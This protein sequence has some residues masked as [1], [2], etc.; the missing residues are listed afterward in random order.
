MSQITVTIGQI[1][2]R[3]AQELS[4]DQGATIA[5]AIARSGLSTNG[6]EIRVNNVPTRE[7]NTPL[8]DEDFVSLVQ[9]IK[10]N[11]G[12]LLEIDAII[13]IGKK[14]K[15][16]KFP[17]AKGSLLVSVK[18]FL[19][20]PGKFA[21]YEWTVGSAENCEKSFVLEHDTTIKIVKKTNKKVVKKTEKAEKT[22]EKITKAPKKAEKKVD[23]SD[24]MEVFVSINGGE[25]FAKTLPKRA[26][27]SALLKELGYASLKDL[28]SMV[29]N[30]KTVTLTFFEIKAGANVEITVEEAKTDNAPKPDEAPIKKPTKKVLKK[31]VKKTEK[32]EKTEEKAEK[33]EKK[34]TKKTEEA[35]DIAPTCTCDCKCDEAD[36]KPC[37]PEVEV[38]PCDS[39][40]HRS[41]NEVAYNGESPCQMKE[42]LESF[43]NILTGIAKDANIK[44]DSICFSE[45]KDSY[46]VHT[47]GEYN[48]RIMTSP[49][50]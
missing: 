34:V 32:A 3:P 30:G 35:K 37:P 48:L 21:D 13:T 27:V 25:T 7:L 46:G 40:S 47:H 2:G 14:E 44:V 24:T 38:A 4:L 22:E 16:Q 31:V 20:L 42:H 6:Y 33:A 49:I 39:P 41:F 10:G 5:D 23:A 15:K 45:A 50:K 43:V 17:L 28:K 12:D 36:L 18:S 19:S 26:R 29:V 11:Y 1:P 8:S 9:S